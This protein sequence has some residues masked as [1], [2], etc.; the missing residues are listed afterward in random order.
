MNEE[1]VPHSAAEETLQRH[2]FQM[3]RNQ[4]I[5]FVRTSAPS[6]IRVGFRSSNIFQNVGNRFKSAYMLSVQDSRVVVQT[7]GRAFPLDAACYVVKNL[8]TGEIIYWPKGTA[9]S[10]GPD[11]VLFERKKHSI[12][13]GIVMPGDKELTWEDPIVF[14]FLGIRR[15][16]EDEQ[17]VIYAAG[18]GGPNGFGGM[19]SGTDPDLVSTAI[20][21]FRAIS[22]SMEWKPDPTPE[23]QEGED[24]NDEV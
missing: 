6:K 14:A 15:C 5:D 20:T 4:Q 3:Q 1:L 16:S 17:F 2:L 11:V 9:N 12:R 10:V 8:E 18:V 22:K 21:S 19:M 24:M 23:L 13:F 7:K